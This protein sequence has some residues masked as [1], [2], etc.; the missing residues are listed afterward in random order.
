MGL[1]RKALT[2]LRKFLD[3]SPVQEP[4][5]HPDQDDET[6]V[7]VCAADGGSGSEAR[8]EK[9]TKKIKRFWRWHSRRKKYCVA[10]AEKLNQ[11]QAETGTYRSNRQ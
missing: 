3:G 1:L 6:P 11:K 5:A 7:G 10:E 8:R 2:R 9:K 4:Q